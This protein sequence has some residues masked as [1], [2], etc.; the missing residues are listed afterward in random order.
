MRSWEHFQPCV[1]AKSGVLGKINGVVTALHFSHI[2]PERIL[3][4]QHK[5]LQ[6]FNISGLQKCTLPTIILA[7]GLI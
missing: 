5:E 4:L 2:E 6:S 7:I 1:A 3:T